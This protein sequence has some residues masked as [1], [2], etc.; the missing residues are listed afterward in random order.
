MTK[1]LKKPGR[2]KLPEKEKKV[3]L[4]YYI[5]KMYK[6]EFEKAVKPLLQTYGTVNK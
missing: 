1:Q 2:A 3:Q 5:P 4:T 6:V